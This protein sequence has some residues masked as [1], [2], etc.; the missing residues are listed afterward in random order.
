VLAQLGDN[1]D[2]PVH[3]LS[4]AVRQ[5]VTVSTV[6]DD[7]LDTLAMEFACAGACAMVDA[8]LP[9]LFEELVLQLRGLLSLT[10]P[11]KIHRFLFHRVVINHYQS[12]L[13]AL[14]GAKSALR[15]L[16]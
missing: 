14:A 15:L 9:D 8:R 16:P 10:L 12:S 3:H 5:M 6:D 2:P 11:E 4:K 1:L 13:Q 7:T